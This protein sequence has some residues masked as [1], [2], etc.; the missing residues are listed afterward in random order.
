M[1]LRQNIPDKGL[2]RKIFRNKDLRTG[3]GLQVTGFR[4][5]RAILRNEN[6]A[7]K[8][9]MWRFFCKRQRL[10]TFKLSKSAETRWG[11][12]MTCAASR[13]ANSCAAPFSPECRTGGDWA[14]VIWRGTKVHDCR[15]QNSYCRSEAQAR[16][17]R[18]IPGFE[19]RETWAAGTRLQSQ[20]STFYFV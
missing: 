19:N 12:G 5:L 1:N 16:H 15:S 11:Q 13:R 7:K 9:P 4:D 17:D 10:I 8:A 18:G 3:Y 6:P 20:R 2:I 14:S